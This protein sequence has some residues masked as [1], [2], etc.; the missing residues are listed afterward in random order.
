MLKAQRLVPRAN[1]PASMKGTFIKN[2]KAVVFVEQK[3]EKKMISHLQ[4]R[5]SPMAYVFNICWAYKV[6]TNLT[7]ARWIMEM[8]EQSN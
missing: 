5:V 8:L 3:G 6:I 2:Q 4:V 7:T 1:P